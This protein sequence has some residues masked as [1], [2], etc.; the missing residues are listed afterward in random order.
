M[1]LMSRHRDP[2][3]LRAYGA[4][5]WVVTCF[6]TRGLPLEI[7]HLI[8]DRVFQI[9]ALD[10]EEGHPT[11][12][13]WQEWHWLDAFERPRPTTGTSTAVIYAV[14]RHGAW[15]MLARE[16]RMGGQA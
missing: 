2:D 3:A 7:I 12:L 13:T 6:E 14:D 16:T 5:D 1:H 4:P 15:H 10:Y 9:D 11:P 8:G